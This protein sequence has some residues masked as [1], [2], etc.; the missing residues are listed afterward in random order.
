MNELINKISWRILLVLATYLILLLTTG[1]LAYFDY[2]QEK[3]P[4]RLEMS[5]DSEHYKKAQEITDA[6]T[7]SALLK[8]IAKLG[9]ELREDRKRKGEIALQIF[10]VMVGSLLSFLTI[11]YTKYFDKKDVSQSKQKFDGS[12]S[13]QTDGKSNEAIT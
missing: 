4:Y 1:Y 9:E 5:I 13:S 2:F 12:Q 3:V 6:E 8:E 10:N 7:K 11:V